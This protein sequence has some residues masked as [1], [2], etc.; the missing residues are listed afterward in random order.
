MLLCGRQG[1]ALSGHRDYG[2]ISFE[3]EPDGNDGNFRTLLRFRGK[4]DDVLK[5]ALNEGGGNCQYTS[6]TIQN[7]IIEVCQQLILHSLVKKI[8]KCSCFSVL[9]DETTDIANIEQLSLCVR[10][11][12]EGIVQETFLEFVP[13]L[14]VTGKG[15]ATSIIES[16]K[17]AGIDITK[18]RGQG[19]DGA[20]SMSGKFN[21]VQAHIRDIVPSALYVHC[22]A[23]SLNLVVSNACDLP[24]I[25]NCM[26]TAATL[27]NI[28]TPQRDK[29]CCT[30][31]LKK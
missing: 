29:P 9:A 28:L 7:E 21:G 26:G 23:H 6:P 5:M 11:I 3:D 18:M 25:R 30:L 12:D 10:Y 8:N 16:L 19:F 27:N 24:S 22:A 14:D 31:L 13:V 15:I 20:A 4:T 2:R 17:S 1:L